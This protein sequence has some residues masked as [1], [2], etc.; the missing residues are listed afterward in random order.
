MVH[1]GSGWVSMGRGWSC[2]V[3]PGLVGSCQVSPGLARSCQVLTV[4]DWSQWVS[5]GLAEF[6]QVPGAFSASLWILVISASLGGRSVD[7]SRSQQDMEGLGGSWQLLV[8]LS[9]FLLASAGL[10]G[11]CQFLTSLGGSCRHENCK[12]GLWKHFP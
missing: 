4:L 9:V 1:S 11:S 5:T 6:C 2:Q 3:L 7:L 10:G 12:P 8:A